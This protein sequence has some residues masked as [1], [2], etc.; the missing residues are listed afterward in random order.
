[1]GLILPSSFFKIPTSVKASI[2]DLAQLGISSSLEKTVRHVSLFAPIM[3]F[4][5]TAPSARVIGFLGFI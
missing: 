5:M 2:E 3:L 1:L 4:I